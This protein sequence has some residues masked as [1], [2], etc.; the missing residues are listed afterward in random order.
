MTEPYYI[1]DVTAALADDQV[2]FMTTDPRITQERSTQFWE[3]QLDLK[4]GDP[5]FAMF[6]LRSA[7]PSSRVVLARSQPAGGEWINW[8]E[9]AGHWRSPAFDG[10]DDFTLEVHV[11][12]Y[13]G[14]IRHGSGYFRVRDTG[15][16]DDVT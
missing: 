3:W 11:S 6:D 4:D 9:Q 8:T 10:N 12:D 14:A 1:A 5:K 2:T 16:G 13:G 7:N 15:G